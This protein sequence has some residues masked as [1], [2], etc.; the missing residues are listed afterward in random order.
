MLKS[1]IVK[2]IAEKFMDIPFLDIKTSVDVVFDS[3]TESM[4]KSDRVEI[5]GFG[6]FEGRKR[7]KRKARNPKS[8]ASVEL[9]ERLHPFFKAS[10]EMIMFLNQGNKK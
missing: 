4:L 5:R 7:G 1:D 3:I 6:T 9:S 8:G 10:K 2:R